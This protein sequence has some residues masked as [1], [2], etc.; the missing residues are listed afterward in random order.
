MY[1]FLENNAYYVVLIVNLI[2]WL[3]L[4]GYLFT[5]GSSLKKLLKEK[6]TN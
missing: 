4:F 1:T 2:I 3:G 6:Q 5:L